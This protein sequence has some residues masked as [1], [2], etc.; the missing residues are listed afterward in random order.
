MKIAIAQLNPTIGDFEKNY[1]T[2]LTAIQKAKSESSNLIIFPELFLPGYPLLDLIF[3]HDFLE[4]QNKVLQKLTKE[5]S[6]D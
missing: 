5:T 3:K 2:A 6:E 4:Q 1:Q